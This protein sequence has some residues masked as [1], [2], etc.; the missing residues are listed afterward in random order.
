MKRALIAVG[1]GLGLG[2]L[3]L[4]INTVAAKADTCV[5]K[6]ISYKWGTFPFDQKVIDH[7]YICYKISNATITYRATS[8]DASD[9]LCSFNNRYT[10]KTAGGVGNY[11]VEWIDGAHFTCPTNLPGIF[12]HRNDAIGIEFALTGTLSHPVQV[13]RIYSHSS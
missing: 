2:L 9:T 7:T 3:F 13:Y 10:Y 1:I 4:S 5:S 12:V 8:V 6:S 11:Y